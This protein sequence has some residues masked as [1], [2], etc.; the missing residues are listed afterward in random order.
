M[1]VR[2][3]RLAAVLLLGARCGVQAA[4][5]CT[6]RAQRCGGGAVG[7]Q[8]SERRSE[9]RSEQRVLQAHNRHLIC[10]NCARSN[11]TMRTAHTV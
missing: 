8:S 10:A 5:R 2:E 4:V 6:M 7:E 3:L 1:V 11:T 9:Q